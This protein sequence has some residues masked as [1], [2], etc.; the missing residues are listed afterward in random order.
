[1]LVSEVI[2][3]SRGRS[4]PHTAQHTNLHTFSPLPGGRFSRYRPDRGGWGALW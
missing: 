4:R 1:V 3:A 2:Y